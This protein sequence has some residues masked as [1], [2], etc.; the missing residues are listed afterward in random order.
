VVVLALCA[1]ALLVLA[2]LVVSSGK[3]AARDWFMMAALGAAA[4]I[5][6]L[7]GLWRKKRRTPTR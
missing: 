7:L 3:P 5:G 6:L 1:W 2:T 4:T